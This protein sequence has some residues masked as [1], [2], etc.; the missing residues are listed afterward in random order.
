[1]SLTL[2]FFKSNIL[3]NHVSERE[4]KIVH[5]KKCKLFFPFRRSHPIPR[6]DNIRALTD[7]KAKI[8]K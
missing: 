8:A 6:S 3:G 2:L 1:M 4:K 7:R 5:V